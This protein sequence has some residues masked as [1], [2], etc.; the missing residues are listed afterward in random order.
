MAT[1]FRRCMTACLFL[2]ATA[3]GASDAPAALPTADPAAAPAT[4]AVAPTS[5]A[6]QETVSNPD[7]Y[8]NVGTADPIRSLDPA[9]V[10]DSGSGGVLFNIYETLVFWDGEKP[11]QYVARLATEVP[12][13]A[14]GL[15]RDEGRTY[16]F[17]VREGIE[18]TAGPVDDASGAPIAGSGVLSPAD[19]A[20][21]FQRGMLQNRAGGPQ[22]LLLDPLLGVRSILQLA[23][24]IE[25]DSSG[26]AADA[27]ASLDDVSP[28][29]LDAVCQRVKDSVSV[30]GNTVVFRLKEPFAP[31]VQILSG[32]WASIVDSEW[33][34]AEVKNEAGEV[35]KRAGWD[36]TCATWRAFHDPKIE[37]TELFAVANGTG[38]YKL[39]S[40][41]KEEEIVL[42][43]NEEYWRER[44]AHIARIVLKFV[45]E[46]STRLLMLETG[47]ADAVVIPA[48]NRDQV[49][50]L[51]EKGVLI[52]IPNLPTAT[53]SFFNMNE[54]V[55]AENNLYIGSGKLDGAGIPPDFF[56]DIDVRKGFAYAFD[57]DTYIADGLDGDG[58]K[59]K[60]PIPSD[61]LGH[62]PDVPTYTHDPAKAAEHFA[63]AFDGQLMETGFTLMVP[64]SPGSASAQVA[65]QIYQQSLEQI[66]PKFKL[67]IQE[68]Q[69]SQISKDSEADQIAFRISG[70]HEDY[71]DPHNWAYP[72]LGV[73]GYY[74]RLMSLPEDTQA[75]IE[76]LVL[77][78]RR[79]RDPAERA[80]TYGEIQRL[81][82]DEALIIPLVESI[83]RDF[84]RNWLHDV[85]RN[86]AFPGTYYWYIRKGNG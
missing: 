81:S 34:M 64:L 86:P 37:D 5:P 15:L 40:W 41:R 49:R 84:Q 7:T 72:I 4:D 16:V 38:P 59:S 33:V 28:A 53:M 10:Y 25:A 47:D 58:I 43:R 14:N 50:P 13:E 46:W 54:L 39:D 67:V 48:A 18:F 74:G 30:D 85:V 56:A 68:L 19:V 73:T 78:A 12:S 60:G 26:K 17:P 70:W 8:V 82:Y 61:I 6:A 52:E 3:C 27:I 20:Y 80:K 71:H 51:V 69:A 36:G 76:D 57:W 2:F 9:M 29:T 35:V 63:K 11:D 83:G 75:T 24:E 1:Q 45:P 31:F 22:S 42:V 21:S 77:T 66:N 65:F 32:Y 44:P 23:R 79:E 55:S 62:D